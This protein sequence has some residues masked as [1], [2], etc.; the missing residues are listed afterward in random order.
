M[1]YVAFAVD[2]LGVARATYEL[3]CPDDNDAN[4]RAQPYRAP[5]AS[6]HPDSYPGVKRT[7]QAGDYMRAREVRSTPGRVP[8]CTRDQRAAY[9]SARVVECI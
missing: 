1:R 2:L 8:A 7:T 5:D 4:D 6:E 9:T 3:E